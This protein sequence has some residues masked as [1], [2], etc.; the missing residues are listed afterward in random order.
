MTNK[1]AI[2]QTPVL[3][4]W[5]QAPLIALSSVKATTMVEAIKSDSA[6]IGLIGRFSP[7]A[8]AAI[9]CHLI[10]DLC[11][12]VNVEKNNMDDKQV[13]AT[14]QL[15]LDDYQCRNLK[16]EDFKVIF[17]G[18]K[19]GDYGKFYNRV[20]GQVIFDAIRAYIQRREAWVEE[21][22]HREHNH[23]KENEKTNL[24]APEVVEMYKEVL[25]IVKSAEKEPEPNKPIV[26]VDREK[27]PREKLIQSLFV[28]FFKKW[29][30]NPHIVSDREGKKFVQVDGKILD[31]CEYVEHRLKQIE[32]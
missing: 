3:I 31:E 21:N 19:K 10:G 17:D 1:P 7:L 8:P 23:R 20:D 26:K 25:R 32:Q 4:T 24:I 27:S 12:F 9:L 5:Q 22:N 28:E 16:P 2:A 11:K 30:Q 14:V 13:D 29:E 6:P 18:L 15:I